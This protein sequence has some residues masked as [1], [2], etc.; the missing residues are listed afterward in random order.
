MAYGFR[1]IGSRFFLISFVFFT[2]YFSLTAQLGAR[3]RIDLDVDPEDVDFY[4]H[5]VEP[6]NAVYDNFG[7]LAIVLKHR[8]TGRADVYNWG[9]FDFSDPISFS[10]QFYKGILPYRLA[11]YPLQYELS[12]YQAEKRTVYEDLLDLNSSQKKILMQR[13]AWHVQP[14]HL[15]YQYH[16]FFDNCATRPRDYLDEALSGLLRQTYFDKSS[17]ETFRDMVRGHFRS[18]PG[19]DVSLD[20]LMNSNLDRT[21]TLWEKAFLPMTLRELLLSL[22]DQA[23]SS[24]KGT[25]IVTQSRRL[26][27][28]PA[29]FRWPYSGHLVFFVIMMPLML[30]VFFASMRARATGGAA[31]MPPALYRIMAGVLLFYGLYFG[32]I[33]LL[34]PINWAVSEHLDLH[35]NANMF[36]F[37]PT[38]LIYFYWGLC[39]L[40]RGGPIV[41]KT[42]FW[43]RT[44][45]YYQHIH[46]GLAIAT[47]LVA[48]SGLIKQDI[49]HI[50]AFILPAIC[51]V[52]IGLGRWGCTS[53]EK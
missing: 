3:E 50:A 33:G 23:P 4:L 47:V 31:R 25:K 18:L 30:A 20:I 5:T 7:H 36:F 45:K 12:R 2:F 32:L 48:F 40:R 9:I 24:V 35:H 43:Y 52:W 49:S 8:P 17:G 37:W 28:F 27:D 19:M 6:G 38:D 34:M 13:L 16:Y 10:L 39:M 42:K 11:S 46:L 26:F 41:C 15:V 29:G 14:E 44:F 22:P 1:R 53:S 21:M 51:L